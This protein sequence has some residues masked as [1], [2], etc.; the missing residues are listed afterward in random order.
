MVF[1]SLLVSVAMLLTLVACDSGSSQNTVSINKQDLRIVTLDVTKMTC[2]ACPLTVRLAL[3]KVPG[4]ASVK[5]S[6]NTKTATISFDSTVTNV[7]ALTTATTNAGY[8]SSVKK[9]P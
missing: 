1:K 9:K 8:P 7:S 5:V 2:A 4:V 6:Y 3:K